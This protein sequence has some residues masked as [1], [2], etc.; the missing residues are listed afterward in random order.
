MIDVV[1]MNSCFDQFTNKNNTHAYIFFMPRTEA[2]SD[3]CMNAKGHVSKDQ[4]T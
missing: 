2:S 3:R 1:K 4:R